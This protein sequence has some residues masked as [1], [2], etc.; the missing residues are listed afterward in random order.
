M[1]AP[2]QINNN[3]RYYSKREVSQIGTEINFLIPKRQYR[4]G[5]DDDHEQ[6]EIGL[7]HVNQ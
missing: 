5:K 1:V 2:S 6:Y 4:H 3:R 7:A